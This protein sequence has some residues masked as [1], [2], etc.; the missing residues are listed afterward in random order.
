MSNSMSTKEKW[1][2]MD[3]ILFSFT[4]CFQTLI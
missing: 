1:Q 2:K 4:V 3:S